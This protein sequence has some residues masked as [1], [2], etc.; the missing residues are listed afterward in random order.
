MRTIALGEQPVSD[1]T[2]G[3]RVRTVLTAGVLFVFLVAGIAIWNHAQP[4]VSGG[5]A[6]CARVDAI[7]PTVV[8]RAPGQRPRAFVNCADPIPGETPPEYRQLEES[9]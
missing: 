4:A 3:V 1:G 5:H 2:G 6:R 7:H 9:R 8:V